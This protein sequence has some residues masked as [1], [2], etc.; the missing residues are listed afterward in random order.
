MNRTAAEQRR[1][2]CEIAVAA[3]HMQTPCD[4]CDNAIPV[5]RMEEVGIAELGHKSAEEADCKS[6]EVNRGCCTW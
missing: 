4:H 2:C 1:S 3:N 5:S 6:V